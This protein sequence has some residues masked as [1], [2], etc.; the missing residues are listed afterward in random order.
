M[1]VITCRFKH[2]K[3][4]ILEVG[5]DVLAGLGRCLG[6]S[7]WRF[8]SPHWPHLGALRLDGDTW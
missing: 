1:A 5:E 7:R 6:N 3:L 4:L 2:Q 8:T